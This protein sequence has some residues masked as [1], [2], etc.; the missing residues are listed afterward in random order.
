MMDNKFYAE[1]ESNYCINNE[2]DINWKWGIVEI[3]EGG[4]Y[5]A[6]LKLFTTK[7]EESGDFICSNLELALKK[8]ITSKNIRIKSI[9]RSSSSTM[10][11]GDISDMNSIVKRTFTT[12][13]QGDDKEYDRDDFLTLQ[14]DDK[15]YDRDDFLTLL[16][17]MYSKNRLVDFLTNQNLSSV[18]VTDISNGKE[19]GKP[20][21]SCK[22]RRIIN[23]VGRGLRKM[24]H[25]FCCFSST[26]VS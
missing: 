1:G 26:T 2:K 15:E 16:L 19:N 11:D 4:A 14:G 18:D 5:S 9:L 22:F 13:V 7:D 23:S 3:K 21:R 25:L 12:P 6:L 10:V 24:K 8:K 17:V 20:K